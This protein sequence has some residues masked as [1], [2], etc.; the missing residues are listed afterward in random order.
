[1]NFF[2]I[3]SLWFFLCEGEI[4]RLQRREAADCDRKLSAVYT[5]NLFGKSFPTKQVMSVEITQNKL[6]TLAL[7]RICWQSCVKLSI[8]H[9]APFEMDQRNPIEF[10]T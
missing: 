1:M 8:S 10:K 4:M 5:L 6:S 9:S 7:M 2:D 3:L